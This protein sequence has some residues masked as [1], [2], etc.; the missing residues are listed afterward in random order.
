MFWLLFFQWQTN[1]SAP[2]IVNL[3]DLA[4]RF[5]YLFYEFAV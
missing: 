2:K 1:E 3:P 5:G 4:N